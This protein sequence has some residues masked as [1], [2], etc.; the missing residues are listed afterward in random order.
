[1][2]NQWI[3]AAGIQL[4]PLNHHQLVQYIKLDPDLEKEWGLKPSSRSISV[5][6]KETLEDTIMPSV[7]DKSKNYLFS[8]LWTVISKDLNQMVAAICF[9]GE[10]NHQG[11]IEIGY[12]TFES[13]Q[14]KGFMTKAVAAIIPWASEQSNVVS[15]TAE[16]EKSNSA[17]IVVLEKNQFTK[18]NEMG[19]KCY[20]KLNLK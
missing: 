17:S 10:P 19:S 20:W 1:M 2:K 9:K 6:L 5:E 14:G 8:T 16:T 15:I 4:R 13:F 3:E 12:G 7:A 18:V 11:E